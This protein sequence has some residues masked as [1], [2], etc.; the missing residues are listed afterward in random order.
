[1][2]SD[3]RGRRLACLVL[4][5]ACLAPAC[6]SSE[7]PAAAPST[8][9]APV[10]T[11]AN[12]TTSTASATPSSLPAA[13]TPSCPTIPLRREPAPDRPRYVLHVDVR[14]GEAMVEGRQEVEFT[15]DRD[16]DRLVFRL[17]PNGPRQRAIAARLDVTG[18]Q[19]D[20]REMR[21]T[22][23]D[24]TTLVARPGAGIRA[25]QRVR[26]ALRWTLR[27][28]R[29]VRDRISDEGGSVRLGSFF[30]IL[31]WQPGVGW[32]DDPPTTQFAEASTAPTA[33]FDLTVTAP[34]GFGVLASGVEDRPGHWMA[35]A[36]RDVAVAVGRFTVASAVARSPEPVRVTVGVQQGVGEQPST[37]LQKAVTVLEDFGRRFGPYPWPTFTVSVTPTLRSGI[38]YPGHVMQGP[39]TSGRSLTHEVGHQWF[40]ALVGNNQAR[41]PWIDEGGASWAEA[42]WEG[43]LARFRGRAIPPEARGRLG[44]PMTYW[45]PRSSA[46]YPGVY[47]QGVQAMAALGSPDLVDC[48]LR[49][50]VAQNAHRIATPADFVAAMRAVFPDAATALA[51]FGIRG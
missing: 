24:P 34:E 42:R 50:F 15:P 44:E 19:V 41:D 30:P 17:W 51:T 26:A 18:L 14:P 6:R 46:Y 35:T 13:T 48:A 49:V 1:M 33:D 10:A 32:L 7:R 21:P 31:E 3:A 40:Y 36:M 23:D 43:A 38:E 12:P 45:D 5:A 39:G 28:P 4:V 27:L 25:G 29:A 2:A 11:T 9:G 16:T 37:Y 8:T 47:V 22:L 20:G